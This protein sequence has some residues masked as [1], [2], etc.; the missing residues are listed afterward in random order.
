MFADAEEKGE[1][2]AEDVTFNLFEDLG[3]RKVAL[4]REL[5]G[6]LD[7]NRDGKVDYAEFKLLFGG[8]LEEK[9]TQGIAAAL[10]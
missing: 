10:T 7:V 3:K 6:K 9:I 4:S 8:W 5:A 2:K 1:V